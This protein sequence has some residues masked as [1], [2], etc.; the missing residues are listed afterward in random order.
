MGGSNCQSGVFGSSGLREKIIVPDVEDFLDGR[1]VLRLTSDKILE[2][3]VEISFVV[4]F[5]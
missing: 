4:D 1:F 5:H 2:I 3:D